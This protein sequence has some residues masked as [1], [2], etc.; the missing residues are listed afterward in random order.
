[1]EV[2]GGLKKSWVTVM[3]DRGGYGVCN[4]EVCCR[5]YGSNRGLKKS[6]DSN[7]GLGRRWCQ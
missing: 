7:D 6:G 2:T 3:R 1:M 5:V 4:E